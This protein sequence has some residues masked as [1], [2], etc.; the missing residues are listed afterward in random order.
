MSAVTGE[1]RRQRLDPEGAPAWYA[2]RTR[3]RHEKLVRDELAARGV[4]PFLPLWDRR[5]R[6][7]DR[8]VTV[9]TPLFPGYCFGRFDPGEKLRVLTTRGVVGIVGTH[10]TIEAVA[11]AE[12]D[13]VRALVEGPLRYDPCPFLEVGQEVEV[14]RGPLAGVR[15]R[16]VRKGRTTRLVLAVNLIRQ[17]VSLDIDAADVAPV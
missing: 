17:G 4:E 3:S 10:G 15:G 1:E 11:P 16:L 5:S 13:A 14:I 6:W 8:Y 7:K 2:I 12:L 9:A